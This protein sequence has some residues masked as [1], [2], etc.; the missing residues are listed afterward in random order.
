M[1]EQ[2]RDRLLA[3]LFPHIAS[4]LRMALSNLHLASTSLV[5]ARERESDPALD[6]RAAVLDQ[7]YYQL[8]R[9][10]SNLT[11]AMSLA[12]T[13]PLPLQNQDIVEIIR[14]QCETVSSLAGLLGLELRFV[15]PMESHICGVNRAALE[16]LFYQL[17]SNALKFTKAGS[18]TVELK[19]AGDRLLLSVSDTGCGISEE[20]LP[21]LFDRFLHTDRLDPV[22]HGL[23]LGLPLCRRIMDRLGGSI[24]A[25]SQL[26]K[27]T[28]ITCSLP[29][30]KSGHLG[31][32]D[33]RVDY[34]GGF[35]PTLLYL[36][37]A[38]PREAFMLNNQD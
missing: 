38:L 10:V 11:A 13:S 29:D 26:G 15:C 19:Q 9:L 5:P 30:R 28:K 1:S 21:T 32:S 16:Q 36:A 25:E 22:P 2:D 35:N 33:L 23:G 4:Q 17:L 18:V 3:E 31:V 8:L 6:A 34:T 12:E 14:S 24:M 7:S 27:G 37:D 20:L